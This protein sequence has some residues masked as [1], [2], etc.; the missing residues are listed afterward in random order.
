MSALLPSVFVGVCAFPLL[1]FFFYL[2]ICDLYV[3]SLSTCDVFLHVNGI[4][5]DMASFFLS[6]LKC[7]KNEFI[8]WPSS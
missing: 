3:S 2:F 1:L 8:L 4:K 6:Y 5:V 7:W